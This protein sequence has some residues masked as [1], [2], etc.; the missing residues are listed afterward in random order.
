MHPHGRNKVPQR[1][2]RFVAANLRLLLFLDG[3]SMAIAG[4]CFATIVLITATDVAM[5]YIFNA[6]LVWAYQLISNYLMVTVFFLAL[7]ATQRHG[8]N[9]GV[10]MVVRRLPER[11]RAGLAAICLL[12]MIVYIG[13]LAYAGWSVFIDAWTGGDVLAGVIAWPRWPGM[14]LV[15]VGSVLLLVRLLV[16]LAAN[17]CAA[18][19][20]D[21][22]RATHRQMRTRPGFGSE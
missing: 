4:I 11:L 12:L 8:Q 21:L 13:L 16:E 20:G 22:D 5:R 19:A 3:L 1:L 18:I 17:A 14:L 10:D 15:P 9:I 6:P 7:A 2:L